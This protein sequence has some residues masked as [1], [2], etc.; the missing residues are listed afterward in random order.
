MEELNKIVAENLV[1][2][3]K[4]AGL[5]QTEVALKLQYSDK[6]ISKWETGEIMPS[7]ANLCAL[8]ELYGVSLDQIVRPMDEIVSVQKKDYN[9]RNKLIISLLA[10]SVVWILATTLFVYVNTFA[11]YNLWTVFLWAVPV[12][13]I[14][15]IVFN[16]LW[17]KKKF[18]YVIIS[19][20]VWSLLGCFYIQL[21][22]YNLFPLFFLGIPTQI[23]IILWSG[24]KSKKQ[25][26]IEKTKQK[27]SA[28]KLDVEEHQNAT[29]SKKNNTEIDGENQNS[30]E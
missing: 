24:L 10:I 12:S 16:S 21:L 11:K 22:D 27:K 15:G 25:M 23:S 4:S 17:G 6:T 13:C 8:C 14:V 7:V 18:N 1:K 19:V 9:K 3:R 28:K 5:K 2:L 30:I 29:N 20:L 26:G